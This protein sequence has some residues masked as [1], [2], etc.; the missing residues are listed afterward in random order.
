MHTRGPVGDVFS[1]P[2]QWVSCWTGSD[3][4]ATDFAAGRSGVRYLG[5]N[6][7]HQREVNASLY[8][9]PVT[10]DTAK[11]TPLVMSRTAHGEE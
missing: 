1:V 9:L 11:D 4:T 2:Q 8:S 7:S 10:A 5:Q 3:S 6:G